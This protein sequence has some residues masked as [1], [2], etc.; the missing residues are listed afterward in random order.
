MLHGRRLMPL[1]SLDRAFDDSR[2]L[3]NKD[4]SK[5][6]KV[7]CVARLTPLL[8]MVA[9]V[10]VA[11]GSGKGSVR[12]KLHAMTHSEKLYT[13]TWRETVRLLNSTATFT[14][15]LGTE[16]GTRKVHCRLDKF[17]GDWVLADDVKDLEDAEDE[18]QFHDDDAEDLEDAEDK[19]QFHD[20][21]NVADGDSFNFHEDKSIAEDHVDNPPEVECNVQGEYEAWSFPED[22]FELD[23]TPSIFIPG[24]LHIIS[25]I[26]QSFANVLLYWDEWLEYL[27]L[28]CRL[29]SRK[30]SRQRMQ[31][32]CFK[33]H[34]AAAVRHVF[35][36][37]QAD[38]Y[39]GRWGSVMCALAELLPVET[40]LRNAWC[41]ATYRHG[42]VEG[43]R[44]GPQSLC[45]D[46]A[47]EG[48]RS[49]KFWAYSHML[50]Y[51]GDCLTGVST[52][53]RK[54]PM[55]SR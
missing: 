29:L 49:H 6:E 20:C 34:P 7:L 14:G 22:E 12:H 17:M 32:H 46:K 38:V 30:Y 21:D 24:I 54:L 51:I 45:V 48:I 35:D 11:T 53:G 9:G 15:D 4:S 55:P 47:D 13:Q 28:I 25:N 52:M 36:A 31:Q 23:L 43:E 33:D 3:L 39:E 10:P 2:T 41:L 27:R 19:F 8:R 50:H 44:D 26:T 42:G 18:F 1:A 40:V 5:E 16:A 37:F